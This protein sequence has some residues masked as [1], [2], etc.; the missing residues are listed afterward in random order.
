MRFLVPRFASISVVLMVVAWAE[1][2][3]AAAAPAAPG[4]PAE[5]ARTVTRLYD[6]YLHAGD[7]Y[8]DEMH[9]QKQLF[10]PAFYDDLEA[11]FRRAQADKSFL[12]FDPFNGVQVSSYGYPL[13]RC[14]LEGD[15]SD[16]GCYW[17]WV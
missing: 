6:W 11:A 4:C 10:V 13:Q 9:Q 16:E 8:R 17:G 7:A 3:G 1:G 2:G 12:D 5:A 14:R 15:G